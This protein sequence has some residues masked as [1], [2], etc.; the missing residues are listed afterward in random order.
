MAQGKGIY[1]RGNIYWLRYADVTGRVIRESS[2]TG[3]YKAALKV[4]AKHRKDVSDGKRAATLKVRNVSFAELAEEYLKWAK[5]QRAYTSKVYMSRQ[6]VE[7]FGMIPLRRFSVHLL[8]GYQQE[9][10]AAGKAAATINRKFALIK[11]MFHKA[12]DWLMVDDEMLRMVRKVK[13]LKEPPGRLRYLTPEEAQRLIAECSL[14]LQPIVTLAL[15]SGMRCGEILGLTWGDVDLRNG[16]IR[17]GHSKN[18][19]RRDIPINETVRSV[20]AGILRRLDSEYVFCD[21]RGNRARSV[22]NAFIKAC[23]KAGLHDFHFHDLRHSAASFMA[24]AGVDLMAIKQ[25]LGHKT[26]QMTLKYSHLSPNY[27]RTAV[28]ALGKALT[29]Q[30][31]PTAQFA[32]QSIES[33]IPASLPAGVTA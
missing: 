4:L 1:K 21:E 29:S 17:I 30:S 18:G 14:R 11:H 13:M 31:D 9:L 3:D 20:F 32:A 15:N 27:L 19:E 24:M 8:E 25:V 16:L 26:I 28:V 10:L 6:L 5:P 33:S 2:G 23:R 22:K 7:R 12:S